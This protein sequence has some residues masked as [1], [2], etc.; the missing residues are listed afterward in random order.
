MQAFDQT[1]EIMMRYLTP[2]ACTVSLDGDS[3]QVHDQTNV[4]FVK[5]KLKEHG[6][7][8]VRVSY[9]SDGRKR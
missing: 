9:V 7:D 6:L 5:E 4:A 1:Q 3:V 8:D 2:W